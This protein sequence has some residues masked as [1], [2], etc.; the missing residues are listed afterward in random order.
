MVPSYTRSFSNGV[1][2]HMHNSIAHSNESHLAHHATRT[3][4][5]LDLACPPR[6]DKFF[7]V[8]Q[9]V[10]IPKTVAPPCR[11]RNGCLAA[12]NSMNISLACKQILEDYLQKQNGM[13]DPF[14]PPGLYASSNTKLVLRAFSANTARIR[15]PSVG[16]YKQVEKY[17]PLVLRWN[18][19]VRVQEPCYRCRC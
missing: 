4:K 3:T 19:C 2:V 5:K 17:C 1:K 9:V 10:P 11:P 7:L 18:T 13:Q 8:E 6:M 15:Y 12:C 16:P 14:D